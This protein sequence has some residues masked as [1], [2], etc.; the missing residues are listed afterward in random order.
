LVAA[1]APLRPRLR[2]AISLRSPRP[3]W[4]ASPRLA[5][6][7]ARLVLFGERHR[8]DRR[9]LVGGSCSISLPAFR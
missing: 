8:R 7:P 6:C 2:Y 1:R 3:M 4:R 5:R 9:P